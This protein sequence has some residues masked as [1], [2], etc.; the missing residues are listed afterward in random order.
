MARRKIFASM[1]ALFNVH[2]CESRPHAGAAPGYS[3]PARHA[4]RTRP[5]V[6]SRTSERH[7][8]M[9]TRA[10]VGVVLWALV[11]C[12]ASARASASH[13]GAG[14]RGSGAEGSRRLGGSRRRALRVAHGAGLVAQAARAAATPA[15]PPPPYSGLTAVWPPSLR[16][17]VAAGAAAES[18]AAAAAQAASASLSRE[19]RTALMMVQV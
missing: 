19:V 16:Q 5:V 14:S 11:M 1:Y 18:T 10:A 4:A 15:S 13:A 9:C 6:P 12:P 2:C 17:S 8:C 3:R 7:R